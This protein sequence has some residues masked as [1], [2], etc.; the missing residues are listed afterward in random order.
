MIRNESEYDV[1]GGVTDTDAGQLLDAVRQF[2]IDAD[3]WI[4]GRHP[5]LA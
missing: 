2:A 1:A 4:K 3:S 5:Q